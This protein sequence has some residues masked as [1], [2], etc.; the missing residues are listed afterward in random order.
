MEKGK[1]INVTIPRDKRLCLKCK[2]HGWI[3]G[4]PQ[5]LRRQEEIPD[6]VLNNRLHCYRAEYEH[7]TC[8]KAFNG[9]DTYDIRGNGPGCKL[10]KEGKPQEI[11]SISVISRKWVKGVLT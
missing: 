9:I 5:E 4:T 2:Y 1:T 10:F 7:E 11:D 3:G 8:L 6:G